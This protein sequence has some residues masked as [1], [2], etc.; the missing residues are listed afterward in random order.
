LIFADWFWLLT[1]GPLTNANPFAVDRAVY[2]QVYHINM[3]LRRMNT[4]DGDRPANCFLCLG[5]GLLIKEHER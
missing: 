2:L 4:E 5:L 3:D 1:S